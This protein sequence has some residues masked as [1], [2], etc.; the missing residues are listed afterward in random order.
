MASLILVNWLL[1][2]RLRYSWRLLLLTSFGIIAAVTLMATGALYSRALSEA[3][4]RHSLARFSP[5]V[6][7]TQIIVQNRPLDPGDYR[8]L[9]HAV[10]QASDLR[11][12]HIQRGIERFGRVQTGLTSSN[13]PQMPRSSDAPS[14]RPFFMTGF[15]EHSHLTEGNWPQSGGSAGP[16]GVEIDAVMGA[17][18][19]RT[20]GLGLGSQVYIWPFQSNSTPL[21]RSPTV[22]RITLNIVGL[23]EPNDPNE[24][25]WM[26]APNQ[27]TVQPVGEQIETFFY[28]TEEDF[29]GV[30]G[31][32]FP[33]LVG[34]FGF[35][36]FLDSSLVTA[37]AVEATQEAMAGLETDLNKRYPRILVLS[38]MSLTL[39]EFERELTLARVPLYVFISLIML[40]IVYFLVMITGVLGRS[41][42]EEA[43]LLRSRGASLAQITGVLALAEGAVALIAVVSGPFLAWLIVRHLLLPTIVI[44]GSG[45]VPAGLAADMFWMGAAGGTLTVIVLV[46]TA[47]SRARKVMMESLTSRARPYSVS[48]LHRYYIDILAG[49]A[50]G[51]IWWQ[52]RGRDGFVAEELAERGVVVDLTLILGP[53]LGLF[54]AAVLLMR[55][56]PTAVRLLSLVG[57]RSRSAWLMLSL[58]RLARDPIPHGS[59]AVMLMLAAA[60]GVFGATFQSSLSNSQR[61]QALHRVGGDLVVKSPLLDEESA[62]AVGSVL[63]VEA[64]TPVLLKSVPL[65][66]IAPGESATLMAAELSELA[67]AAWF[68]DDFAGRSLFELAGLLQTL[69]SGFMVTEAPLPENT[70]RLGL[71]LRVID[72][73]DQDALLGAT[74]WARLW[75][76][77]GQ[78]RNVSLGSIGDFPPSTVDGWRFMEGE[79][80]DAVSA[81]A[82][83]LV[84][85]SIFLS[86]T[87][88][89]RVTT[90]TVHIDDVT[91]FVATGRTV[92]EDFENPSN[93]L[94]LANRGPVADTVAV[95][96]SGARSEG[97]GLI[98]SWEEPFAGGQRGVHLPP[99]PLPL[100]AIGGPT[101]LLGQEVRIDQG[102][103]AV[104]LRIVATTEHFPTVSTSR[105]PFLLLDLNHYKE[106][107]D[108]LSA[109][110]FE[111][112]DQLWLALDPA[113]DR[114][115]V[116]TAVSARLPVLHS[117]VDREQVADLAE[118][119]PLA[120]GGWD[121]LTALGMGAIGTAVVLTL[122]VF[123]TVSVRSGKTDLSV[124]RALGFSRS[125]FL[126]SV[127]VE[128]LLIAVAAIAAGAAIGYW[129]GLELVEIMDLTPR[130]LPAV[131]PLVPVV[132]G[133][134]LALVLGGLGA[135]TMASV[136]LTVVQ[137]R[138]LDTA[139]ILRESA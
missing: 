90:A 51:L 110:P 104:P 32:K 128:R 15:Q 57:V 98:F 22:E 87:S 117:L 125:Q 47:V 12:G 70:D 72:P 26:G 40:V 130:G 65:L 33:T 122:S 25:Y 100:P 28:L 53:V 31:A 83:P 111:H 68:R 3:G 126:L 139:N 78:Y 18:A 92:I 49:L 81:A 97:L 101:F 120:G 63:G 79:L 66:D 127:L 60:L 129:P 96:P 80:P 74:V 124:A 67:K 103:F 7:N 8:P 69:Q 73:D 64:V 89:T 75:D 52:V 118:S 135:A 21:S 44:S 133:W 85:V 71:W 9:A 113:A 58:V 93:W 17:R 48:F 43:G 134:L 23:A 14:G 55:V 108:L 61:Q 20:T 46:A 91:A 29:F 6:L 77:R 88:F 16:E 41:Q 5:Q 99:G 2:R 50:L 84:L 59:L 30:L 54:A 102:R 19:A 123:S 10:D 76:A 45:D 137:A 27:F 36:L 116:K 35:S 109:G 13:S 138:R 121:G 115:Q 112:P 131:P 106:Y 42:A 4:L 34:V 11:V 24:E 114:Q 132:Q 1:R 136:L 105:G 37:D 94:P 56:L 86:S 38:R 119:N 39:D 62:A 107:L 82:R 95:G